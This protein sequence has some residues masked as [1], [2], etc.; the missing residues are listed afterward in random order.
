MVTK[1]YTLTPQNVIGPLSFIG[2]GGTSRA[3]RTGV[4]Y[5]RIVAGRVEQAAHLA[6]SLQDARRH[7][8]HQ[9]RVHRV[10]L[11]L[12][13]GAETRVPAPCR[14]LPLTL[15]AGGGDE[16]YIGVTREHGFLVDRR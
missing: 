2:D 13:H 4:P 12:L 7:S 5:T 15:G 3:P 9:G 11:T 10:H 1:A 16:Y 8:P 6:H 14:R